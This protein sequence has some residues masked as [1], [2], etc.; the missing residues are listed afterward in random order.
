MPNGGLSIENMDLFL[1]HLVV[2][3]N[4]KAVEVMNS[5]LVH[6]FYIKLDDFLPFFSTWLCDF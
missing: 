2:M 6:D 3:K 5:I 4:Y 1:V